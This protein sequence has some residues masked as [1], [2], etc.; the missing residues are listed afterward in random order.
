MINYINVNYI[1]INIYFFHFFFPIYCITFF[2]RF[3][4]KMF[5]PSKVQNILGVI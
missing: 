5:N 1:N 2:F 4:N 3:L